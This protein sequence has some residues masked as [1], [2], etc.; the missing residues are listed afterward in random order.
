[1]DFNQPAKTDPREEISN[2]ILKMLTHHLSPKDRSKVIEVVCI[3]L[4]ELNNVEIDSI[5]KDIENYKM[6][7]EEREESNKL[8]TK[9]TLS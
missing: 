3:R 6:Q 8:L 1:M 5:T 4:H 9:I 2:E 7:I